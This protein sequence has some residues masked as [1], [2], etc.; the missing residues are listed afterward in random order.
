M[1]GT[2]V[3]RPGGTRAPCQRPR[4]VRPPLKTATPRSLAFSARRRSTHVLYRLR[5]RL[6]VLPSAEQSR[7]HSLM[8]RSYKH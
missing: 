2:S 7:V 8:R 1:E 3:L 6:R 5:Q 4:E